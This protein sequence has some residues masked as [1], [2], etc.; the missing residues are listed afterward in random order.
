MRS[1]DT[2]PV[3]PPHD[4]ASEPENETGDIGS[5]TPKARRS[6]EGFGTCASARSLIDSA[7]DI[8]VAPRDNFAP[9]GGDGGIACGRLP[10]MIW[11]SVTKS[12][13]PFGVASS[14]S[15]SSRCKCASSTGRLSR[16]LCG[17]PS[18]GSGGKAR[19]PLG[20]AHE[21][22]SSCSA[23]LEEAGLVG[24]LGSTRGADLEEKCDCNVE[25]KPSCRT[26][27]VEFFGELS[28]ELSEGLTREVLQAGLTV[29]TTKRHTAM[30][31]GTATA[32]PMVVAA[33][34]PSPLSM[35][36]PGAKPGA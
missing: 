32:R 24:L 6:C 34:A 17:K 28:N 19:A 27:E 7:S 25:K 21:V 9:S 10:S 1:G 13:A 18:P 8:A 35:A 2:G 23:A 31:T 11:P 16:P 30:P 14:S 12:L 5:S 36:A 33:A 26:D 22:R 29:T 3:L 20:V 4:V 15:T